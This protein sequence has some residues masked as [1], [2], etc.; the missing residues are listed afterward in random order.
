MAAV[1]RGLFR[2]GRNSPWVSGSAVNCSTKSVQE[3]LDG[4]VRASKVVVF[5]KGVPDQPRCGFS[6]AV[7]QIFRMHGV[8]YDAHNVLADENIRQGLMILMA[9]L[10]VQPFVNGL[11][12]A[13]CCCRY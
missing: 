11:L 7:V 13:I 8:E 6:N 5:M 2:A 4:V 1:L 12:F 3:Q 10:I 9:P